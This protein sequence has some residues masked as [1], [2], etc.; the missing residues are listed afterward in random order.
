MATKID[1]QYLKSKFDYDI[2]NE[3][4][5]DTVS[6]S[7]T[8]AALFG[9]VYDEMYILAIS[10]DETVKSIEDMESRLDTSEKQEYF[11]KAQ[12]Y[13]LIYEMR[14]GKNSMFVPESYDTHSKAWDWNS[15]TLRIMRFVL[16]FNRPTLFTKR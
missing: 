16:G 2:K 1:A 13:Q 3:I 5:G 15:E 4:R 6:S 10:Q 12:A 8:L 11:R 9:G 14:N 7:N